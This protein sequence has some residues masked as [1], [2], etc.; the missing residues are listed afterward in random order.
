[1]E[2]R[3]CSICLNENRKVKFSTSR[4]NICQYCVTSI[5][6]RF[7]SPSELLRSYKEII[8]SDHLYVLHRGRLSIK[9]EPNV[10]DRPNEQNIINVCEDNVRNN[11][12]IGQWLFRSMINDSKRTLEIRKKY[13]VELA[14]RLDKY[15]QEYNTYLLERKKYT[16]QRANYETNLEVAVEKEFQE[17]FTKIICTK[18][19]IV[20]SDAKV[21]R[22]FYNGYINRHF[23][24]SPRIEKE[25]M[26]GVCDEIIEQDNF[27]CSIC[28]A[29]DTK[30][31]FHVH[32]IIPLDNYGTNKH[33]NLVTLC[34]SCH[35]K[36]HR[37]ITVTRNKKVSRKRHGGEF[38]AIDIETTGFSNSDHIIEIA[39]VKFKSGNPIEHFQSLVDPPVIISF[40]I[41][42]ITGISNLMVSNAP[43]IDAVF[44]NF[45]RFTA[46]YK[47]VFH[48][49]SFDRRFINKYANEYGL[50]FNNEFEDTL[51]LS[52]KKFPKLYN[53]KL[54]T[55]VSYLNISVDNKHRALDDSYA[56]GYVYISCLQGKKA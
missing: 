46:G 47:L 45:I 13:K 9:N 25:K 8:R 53:H 2:V 18:D 11:E 21:L 35:N 28:S 39:A 14:K 17:W 40:K 37:G 15:K 23:E 27:Q 48:N 54:Q 34:Y 41:E 49:A 22:A 24:K 38:I 16:E 26:R 52:R 33:Q 50:P 42:N 3:K 44:P 32:H 5:L 19:F 56:T 12:G 43:T 10:P 31:E 1:M 6:K 4:G 20:E 55:L 30:V 29:S 51:P 36:Q 7:C